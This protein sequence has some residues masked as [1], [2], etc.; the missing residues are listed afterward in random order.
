MLFCRYKYIVCIFFPHGFLK[1]QGDRQREREKEWYNKD[2]QTQ[3]DTEGTRIDE[4]ERERYK[5]KTQILE[6][7]K[8]RSTFGTLS[9]V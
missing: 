1:R 8:E 3:S 2:M 5:D 7:E 9:D 6:R 4:R